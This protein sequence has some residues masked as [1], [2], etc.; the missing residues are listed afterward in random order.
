MRVRQI[1]IG[2]IRQVNKLIDKYKKSPLKMHVRLLLKV[3]KH[4]LRARFTDSVSDAIK[5]AL[6]LW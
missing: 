4:S 2:F 6:G 3:A 5:R 1:H